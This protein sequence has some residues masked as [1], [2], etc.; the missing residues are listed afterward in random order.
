MP[1]P[2]RQLLDGLDQSGWDVRKDDKCF[3]C[4]HPRWTHNDR[5]TTRPCIKVDRNGML[6][7]TRCMC[8]GFARDETDSLLDGLIGFD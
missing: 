3:S 7:E 2:S 1:S 8:R 4:G 6:S 5:R